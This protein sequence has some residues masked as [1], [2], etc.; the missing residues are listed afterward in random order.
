MAKKPKVEN[1]PF[2]VDYNQN[3]GKMK[4]LSVKL[5]SNKLK[6][7]KRHLKDKHNNDEKLKDT[8][9]SISH[10]ANMIITEYLQEQCLERKFFNK[11]IF[12]LVNIDDVKKGNGNAINSLFVTNPSEHYTKRKYMGVIPYIYAPKS[13]IKEFKENKLIKWDK[14]LQNIFND[15]LNHYKDATG[16]LEIALNNYLDVYHDGIY[17]D[18]IDPSNHFGVNLIGSNV[19]AYGV[20]YRWKVKEDYS[21]EIIGIYVCE[22]QEVLDSLSYCKNDKMYHEFEFLI[23]NHN[24]HASMNEI[25]ILKNKSDKLQY[26]LDKINNNIQEEKRKFHDLQKEFKEVQNQ[27]KQYSNP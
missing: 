10:Y 26:K 13:S 27:I 5:E 8:E 22:H 24:K 15:E 20:I 14:E 2:Y 6:T 19:G 1:S 3:G 23:E 18:P 25:E 16:V 21:I 11:S 9:F 7:L 12:A 4:V 17:S